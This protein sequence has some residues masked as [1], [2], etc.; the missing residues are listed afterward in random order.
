MSEEDRRQASA[1]GARASTVA[2]GVDIERF[3]S[4]PPAK[5]MELFYVGSFR[6]RPNIIGF[7]KLRREIMPMVWR[8]FPEARL[9]VVAGPEPDRYWRTDNTDTRIEI[10]GFVEDL[11]PLYAQAAV[12]VVPLEVSAG[13]NIKVMEAM[14]CAR[15]V[16]TTAVGCAGLGLE[17]GR[18]TLIRDMPVDFAAAICDL[19]ADPDRRRCI[20]SEARRTVEQRFSWES[21]AEHAYASYVELAR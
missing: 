16:V 9:R 4:L 17:D 8:R 2:N 15:A 1:E 6:H 21:I 12:V 18:D 19:L 5:G 11:R 7:E 13:T 3:V 10:H 20:A 14:A